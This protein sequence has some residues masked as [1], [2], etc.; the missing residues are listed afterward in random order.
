MSP[1]SSFTECSAGSV[2]LALGLLLL[3]AKSAVAPME[4]DRTGL[5]AWFGRHTH[6]GV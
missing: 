5:P 3:Y 4:M 6:M 2:L 1:D